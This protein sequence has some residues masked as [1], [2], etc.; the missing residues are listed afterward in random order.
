M[1]STTNT[2]DAVIVNG[3]T[4]NLYS[5]Y[6]A[7]TY[8][9]FNVK[10]SRD[11]DEI[12]SCKRVVMPGVGAFAG[13]MHGLEQANLLDVVQQRIS[14]QYPML[15]ICVGM[16]VLFEVSEENGIHPGLS[17]IKGAVKRFPENGNLT[18]PQTGWN[19]LQIEEE[20]DILF[21][22]LP[23]ESY[24]YFNHA[25][26]CAPDQTRDTI[27][28]TAYGIRYASAVR[29]GNIAGV[30][31]HPEKSHKVGLKLLSNFMTL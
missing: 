19:T 26:Y 21:R 15:G 27:S 18:I 4:G 23:Q 11:A 12:L 31:F 2:Y 17:T 25:Y 13:F 6:N 16:Q 14:K 30:Q 9:G 3:D 7:L 8:L 1:P 5:V 24:V 28:S 22:G 20:N 10:I 29:K